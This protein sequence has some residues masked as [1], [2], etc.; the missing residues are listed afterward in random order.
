[1][2]GYAAFWVRYFLIAFWSIP[3]R[4][5]TP[6]LRQFRSEFSILRREVSTA[7]AADAPLTPLQSCTTITRYAYSFRNF[8]ESQLNIEETLRLQRR[9][10][11]S[12]PK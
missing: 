9:N 6:G 4:R 1:M 3:N 7:L 2:D 10:W 5:P 11:R 12:A 8:I